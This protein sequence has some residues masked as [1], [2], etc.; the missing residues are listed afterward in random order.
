[1]RPRRRR[2]DDDVDPRF[3]GQ[4]LQRRATVAA[5]EKEIGGD[6]MLQP[7]TAGEARQ[8]LRGPRDHGIA[9]RRFLGFGDQRGDE[10]G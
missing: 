2:L 1:M 4:R 9:E 3:V 6:A 7:A 8:G 10:G 5:G